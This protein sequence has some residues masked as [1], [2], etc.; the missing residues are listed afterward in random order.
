LPQ[1]LGRGE[2]RERDWG[3]GGRGNCGWDIIYDRRIK[4]E[5][6]TFINENMLVSHQILVQL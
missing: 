3:S 4:R 1:K 5:N 6:Y 2:V